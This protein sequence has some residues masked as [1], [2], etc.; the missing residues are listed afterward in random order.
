M[1]YLTAVT[2]TGDR[3]EALALL[4]RWIERAVLPSHFEWIIVDDG[5]D[6]IK[7]P[8]RPHRYIRREPTPGISLAS[9]LLA[10][11]A[12]ATYGGVVV[13]EDDDWY[14]RGWLQWCALALEDAELVG[15]GHAAYYHVGMRR[16]V[17][18]TNR[19][20]A[21]LSATAFRGRARALLEEILAEAIGP[22]VDV[23][24]WQE[25]RG[26]R[27]LT[28]PQTPGV[29]GIKGMPG[30]RGIGSG[31]RGGCRHDDHGLRKLR[32]WTGDDAMVYAGYC[33]VTL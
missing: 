12:A 7:R 32:E 15:E 11:L 5:V 27:L 19:Q 21:C 2:P 26:S 6:P 20:W 13:L 18:H 9:N 29:V 33:N 4:E 30:R 10:G 23:S 24:L 16:W 31:H 8:S 22:F 14:S 28:V 17:R 3:P 25:W 1:N